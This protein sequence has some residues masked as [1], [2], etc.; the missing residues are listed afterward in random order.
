MVASDSGVGEVSAV[1]LAGGGVANGLGGTARLL[2][3]VL[4][5]LVAGEAA[6]RLT[7]VLHDGTK[8]KGWQGKKGDVRRKI[9]LR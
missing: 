9:R 6:G 2:D 7:A 3:H 8:M 4:L 1:E 5:E